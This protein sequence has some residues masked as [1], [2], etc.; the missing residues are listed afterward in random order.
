[1]TFFMIVV[2]K[3]A[4]SWVRQSPVLHGLPVADAKRHVKSIFLNFRY[5]KVVGPVAQ[6]V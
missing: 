1:M 2:E 5:H 3:P 4:S 6:L